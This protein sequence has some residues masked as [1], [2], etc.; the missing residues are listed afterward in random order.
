MKTILVPTDFSKTSLNAIEYASEIAKKEKAKII[1]LNAYHYFPPSS[2]IPLPADIIDSLRTEST[3]KLNAL[4]K[5]TVK[6]EK[7][8]CETVSK[9]NFAFPAILETAEEKKAD[10]IIMGTTGASGIKEMFMGSNTASVIER[11]K[12]PVLAVPAIAGFNGIKKILYAS[13][14]H[15]S[16][17]DALQKLVE[18]AKL[19][20]AKIIVTHISDE[21]F[22]QF[23]EE[24]Y[25]NNFKN[26]VKRKINYDKISFNLSVGKQVEKVLQKEIDALKPDLLALSMQHRNFFEKI[27]GSSLT[28]KMSYHSEIPV[29]AFHH[30]KE[31]ELVV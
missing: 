23:S 9:F 21:E 10:M 2:D 14:Y 31:A 11:A 20:K 3:S 24:N 16:D 4:C 27:F 5:E 26:I 18:I 30:K 25:L 6:D 7:I 22:N 28:K 13:D 19:F 8:K 29:I 1:L 15:A 12:C 17:L